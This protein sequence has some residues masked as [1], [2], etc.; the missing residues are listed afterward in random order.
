[1][2]I[3]DILILLVLFIPG[4]VGIMYGFLNIVFSIAAWIL[5]FGIAVKFG[6]YFSPLL[7]AYIDTV[8]VR[9]ILA[10][11]G[12]FLISLMIFTALGYFIVKLL[13]RTGLTA[14]DRILGF[15]L[16]LGL[17]GS[18]VTVLVF[19]AGFTALP[20]EPWWQQSIL[21]EPFKLISEWGAGFLPE[22]VSS[23]HSY[24]ISGVIVS[25]GVIV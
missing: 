9:N 22:N 18:I 11:T 6:A 14:A 17:G 16:G 10:F 25:S 3:V 20:Q 4:V 8:L 5:A 2:E 12:L 19:L 13:G 23:Y 24:S 7:E 1:M 15:F 21:I